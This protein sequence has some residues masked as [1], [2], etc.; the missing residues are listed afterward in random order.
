MASP[1][2][3]PRPF[4]SAAEDLEL[5]FGTLDRPA[6]VTALLAACDPAADAAAWW[7]R[8]VGERIAAL[9]ALEHRTSGSD[10]IALT[11][12]CESPGCNARFEIALPHDALPQ[13]AESP[14]VTVAGDDS[15]LLTLRRPTGEDLRAWHAQPPATQEDMLARLH[16]DGEPD[17]AATVRS[18]E[19]LAAADPL[20]DFEIACSCPEC[21]HASERGVD[22][23]GIALHRLAA[24][25]RAVLREV[26]ALASHYGWTEREILSVAAPRRA[27]Y[28]DLI[29]NGDDR[30]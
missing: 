20:L 2:P 19:A 4:G 8:P 15:A 6:L 3:P 1:I 25:Q 28:L 12:T 29:A 5:D 17:P 18:A 23:E 14:T 10:E 13:G 7:R 21:G 27:R 26:H 11:L 9:L 22:L 30:T 16:V 24:R